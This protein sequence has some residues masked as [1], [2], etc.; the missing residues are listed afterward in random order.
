MSLP[1]LV[2]RPAY[3]N[4]P[5][6]R[7]ILSRCFHTS[8]FDSGI[9][10]LFC[11]SDDFSL[12]S[13]KALQAMQES[14]KNSIIESID[15]VVKYEKPSGRGLKDQRANPIK[16]F[17]GKK[18]LNIFSLDE[19]QFNHWEPPR[20]VDLIIAVS[21]G[22]FIPSRI[23]EYA[24]FGGLNVHPSFLPKYWGASPIQHAIINDDKTTGVVVQTLHPEKFD[25]GRII[26]KSNPVAIEID[27]TVFHP[28]I[29]DP[30][31]PYRKLESKL[32]DI[33]ASLLTNV[34]KN[35]H[36]DHVVQQKLPEIEIDE[37]RKRAPLLTTE[38]SRILFGEMTGR[39]VFL[40]SLVFNHLFCYT[41]K[42]KASK[43]PQPYV[44]VTMEPFRLPTPLEYKK[45]LKG[46]TP[47]TQW[48]YLPHI[49]PITG[50]T[51]KN[52]PGS[53]GLRIGKDEWVCFE[54]FTTA[55]KN[56]QNAKSWDQ[57]D[58]KT[59]KLFSRD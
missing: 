17:A 54:Y 37:P 48:V 3:F 9:K 56:R 44:R 11:G 23:L 25:A 41:R 18:S 31:S 26:A 5:S 33:G 42:F 35:Q 58:R 59:V 46:A 50:K 22:L 47:E 30:E 51:V 57:K 32:G 14:S 7:P 52:R 2:F 4:S 55:G 13:L 21:F 34:I 16:D 27:P 20:A 53:V 38:D 24:R 28:P 1:R 40:R 6:R 43:R 19:E 45:S 29:T 10:I 36:Y 15:V 49:S 39:E 12:R 8:R